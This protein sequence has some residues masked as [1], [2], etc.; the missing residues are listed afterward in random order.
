VRHRPALYLAHRVDEAGGVERLRVANHRQI[1]HL[2]GLHRE[3]EVDRAVLV[4][5]VADD[6]GVDARRRLRQLDQPEGQERQQRRNIS[7]FSAAYAFAYSSQGAGSYS[8][9]M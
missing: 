5:P 2:S 7:L 3:A 1:E 8:V 6:C 4:T 9:S